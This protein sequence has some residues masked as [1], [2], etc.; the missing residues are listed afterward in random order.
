MVPSG[1]RPQGDFSRRRLGRLTGDVSTDKVVRPLTIEGASDKGCRVVTNRQHFGTTGVTNLHHVPYIL[2]GASS[3]AT[4]V[5]SVVRGLR[6][7]S[8]DFFRRTRTVGGLVAAFS[9]PRLRVTSQ[10]NLTRS[11]LSG[12]LHL[13]QLATT[14]G[15][16]V[17]A[18]QLARHR[19]HT[20]VQL[21]GGSHSGTLSCVVTGNLALGRARRCVSA[22]LDPGVPLPPGGRPV[23][24]CTVD[25]IQ[26]FCGDL[27][28]LISALRGS[29]LGTGAQ[30]C[31]ASGCVRCGMHVSGGAP[32]ARGYRRL[33]VY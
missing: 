27:S 29:K 7:Q 25:S 23:E 14:R 22:V 5:C 1:G 3:G 21:S 30:G 19:T 18:T 20:L 11:A 8:L 2:R 28:G 26:L 32:R 15:D 10:L 12:G 17:L 16:H 9:V 6:Q 4:T 33:G 24:G 13:L 31:R